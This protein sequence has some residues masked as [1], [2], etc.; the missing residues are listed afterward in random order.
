MPFMILQTEV[1]DKTQQFVE[2]LLTGKLPASFIYH[3]L[4]HTKEV[5]AAAQVIGIHASLSEHDQETVLLAAW[6]HDTGYCFR[7]NAHEEESIRVAREVLHEQQVHP[8]QIEQVVGCIAATKYPQQPKNILEEVLCDADMY[9]ITS[10]GYFEKAELLRQ[11]IMEVTK[12]T[13]SR[14]EWT[15]NNREFLK[16]H[17]FFTHFGKTEM[18]P[19]KERNVKK[20]KKALKEMDEE[21]AEF[22]MD[23]AATYKQMNGID[24]EYGQEKNRE[25]KIEKEKVKNNKDKKPVRG[26]ETMFRTLSA[27]HLELSAIADNKA[28]IM[29]TV[30]SIILSII[31]SVLGRKLEEYPNF[32]IPTLI[33]TIACLGT[34]VFAVLATR[35]NVTS[36]VF[37]KEDVHNK[38]TNLLFFG[39]FHQM[40]LDD[41]EWGM[42]EMMK[43]SEYLY[44]SMIRDNFF[45][46][47][48][49]G[50]K[51]KLLR[52]AYTIFMFGL[53]VA[54][55]S[56]GVAII[57]FPV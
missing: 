52:I 42:K 26:I 1:L 18:E 13:L 57:F 14:R 30:N 37:T 7:Y 23:V 29:I 5:V 22:S 31:V 55:L 46:G 34:I 12:C 8:V 38:R 36:G 33:L 6:L 2:S 3:N 54:I 21:H 51:Y 44:G 41:Y 20:L 43:D 48:V 50:K 19:A 9:H 53:V 32:M 25:K 10:E 4:K 40:N 35:P 17:H 24:K 28:N 45:L 11:E 47:K 56:Y 27:N 39:N 15:E 49:L 16:E